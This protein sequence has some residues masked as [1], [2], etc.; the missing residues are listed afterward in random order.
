[1][2]RHHIFVYDKC[3]RQASCFF[4]IW[5]RYNFE[6]A[7]K[8]STYLQQSRNANLRRRVSENSR[9]YYRLIY[10][11]EK[12]LLKQYEKAAGSYVMN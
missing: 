7:E 9:K 10:K 8:M 11:V 6:N 3:S 4:Q 5:E 1:M 2:Y 12:Y